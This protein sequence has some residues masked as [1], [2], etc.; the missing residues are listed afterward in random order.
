MTLTRTR[1]ALDDA[2]RDVYELRQTRERTE[3]FSRRY[4]GAVALVM[5]VGPVLDSETPKA[6][7]GWWRSHLA[8]DASALMKLRTAVLKRND[9]TLDANFQPASPMESARRFRNPRRSYT[10]MPGV[11]EPVI[12]LPNWLIKGGDYDGKDAIGVLEDYLVKLDKLLALAE[13]YE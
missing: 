9:D 1:Q 10:R 4:R 5:A 11:P 13:P 6:P 7:N 2:R 3:D 12:H 8:P